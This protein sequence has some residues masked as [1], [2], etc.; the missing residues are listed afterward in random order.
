MEP[1]QIIQMLE[2]IKTMNL[3]IDSQSAVLI[4]EELKPI[5]WTYALRDY[6][7][8]IILA[9]TIIGSVLIT[10]KFFYKMEKLNN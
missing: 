6:F 4:V 2:T 7:S 10:A 9:I 5:L 8:A 3:N 1:E